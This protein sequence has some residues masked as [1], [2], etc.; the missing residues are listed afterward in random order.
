MVRDGEDWARLVAE[1]LSR[2]LRFFTSQSLTGLVHNFK[3]KSDHQEV[4]KNKSQ[5]DIEE[6]KN[7]RSVHSDIHSKNLWLFFH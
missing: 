4:I 7:S 6:H 1:S 2:A 5:S 3:E